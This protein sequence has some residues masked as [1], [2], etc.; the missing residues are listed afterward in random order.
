MKTLEEYMSLPYKMEIIPDKDEGGYAVSFPELP[1]CFTVG[2][3]IEEAV[4]NAEDAKRA[5]LEA[6]IEDGVEINEPLDLETYSGQ[7]KLRIPKSLH[8]QLAEQARIEGISMNQYCVY[9][10]SRNSK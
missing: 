1:G 2:E 5:W 10:L 3:T 8:K 4:R 7:F 6:A 9:L